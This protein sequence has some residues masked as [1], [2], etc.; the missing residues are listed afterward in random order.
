MPR[1]YLVRHAKPA[2]SWGEDPDPGLD[3]TGIAQARATAEELAGS[4][5]RLPLYTSPMRRCRETAEPLA[6]LWFC[7]AEPK[8]AVAEIPSPSLNLAARHDW[9]IAAM[10][11]TW[12][13]LH[14]SAPP[15]SI[16]YLVWRKQVIDA[17]LAI[18]RDCVIC[19]HFI[20][21]NVAVGAAQRRDEVVCFRP[22]Y[23]SITVLDV[24]KRRLRVIDLGKQ[25]ETL[26]LARK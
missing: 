18:D 15:G 20:A 17:L 19:T 2:A 1:L 16:D 10:R 25:A 26:V 3:A 22:D 7:D 24:D 23:A 5:S 4:L 21:L 13:Q 6:Q 11:G 12:Q 8:P 14:A 9:L